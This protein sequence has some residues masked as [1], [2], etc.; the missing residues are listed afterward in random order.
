M[1]DQNES[2]LR[3]G[4]YGGEMKL[5]FLPPIGSRWTG[6]VHYPKIFLVV[7]GHR[8]DWNGR[9]STP[10]KKGWWIL[11][12]YISDPGFTIGS[13]KNGGT[14][15]MAYRGWKE[16]IRRKEIRRIDNGLERA[17]MRI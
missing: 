13:M 10:H 11:Y 15:E 16:F 7:T 17:A 2:P 9:G 14:G 8:Y 12:R 5:K 1:R 3:C 6:E 4:I